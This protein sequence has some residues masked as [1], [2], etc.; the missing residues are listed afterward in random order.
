MDLNLYTIPENNIIVYNFL[1]NKINDFI[2]YDVTTTN[3][4]CK[5]LINNIIYKNSKNC[6][7]LISNQ[8][9]SN[10][11]KIQKA[12]IEILLNNLWLLPDDVIKNILNQLGIKN[13]AEIKN[14]ITTHFE[15]NCS[16]SAKVKNIIEIDNLTIQNCNGTQK[17]PL[18]FTF[19]NTGSAQTNCYIST[20]DSFFT[21][22]SNKKEKKEENE[23]NINF[24][25]LIIILIIFFIICI[26]IAFI[27]K[28]KNRLKKIYKIKTVY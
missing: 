14:K 22:T 12:T 20:I 28:L 9:I 18:T 11:E 27:P 5:I 2:S 16:A 4:K 3:I 19:L 17:T 21:N 26:L 15:T 1:K 10:E 8:C 23:I 13:T 7:L 6:E 25:N 24:K